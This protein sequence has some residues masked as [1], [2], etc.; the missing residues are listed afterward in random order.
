MCGCNCPYGSFPTC[1][2]WRGDKPCYQEDENY[3]A[4][5]DSA[6]S[7]AGR[8]CEGFGIILPRHEGHPGQLAGNLIKQAETEILAGNCPPFQEQDYLTLC[9]E[10]RA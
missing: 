8:S 10:L 2:K 4:D 9:Y 3:G 1:R 5:M 7:G 6:H